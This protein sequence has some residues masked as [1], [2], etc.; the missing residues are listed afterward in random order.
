MITVVTLYSHTIVFAG[1]GSI[2]GDGYPGAGD[3]IE[4]QEL[5]AFPVPR[6]VLI[7]KLEKLVHYLPG[8]SIRLKN[9][10]NLFLDGRF[11]TY[12]I[13][14]KS[15]HPAGFE[16]SLW[17]WAAL[18][19]WEDF[20]TLPLESATL[21]PA[22]DSQVKV[23]FHELLHLVNTGTHEL[24]TQRLDTLLMAIF[25]TSPEASPEKFQA[26]L[27]QF[28]NNL[29]PTMHHAW[30]YSDFVEFA[31]LMK[32][33]APCE[34]FET[35]YLTPF[36]IPQK[37]TPTYLTQDFYNKNIFI[38]A[39]WKYCYGVKHDYPLNMT[40]H[41]NPDY[42]DGPNHNMDTILVKQAFSNPDKSKQL[43]EEILEYVTE[44][45]PMT[46]YIDVGP[47]EIEE[48]RYAT[49][50]E[51]FWGNERTIVKKYPTHQNSL[52]VKG[53]ESESFSYRDGGL[54]FWEKF[55]SNFWFNDI[56]SFKPAVSELK[57]IGI[58]F[59]A[60]VRSQEYFFKPRFIIEENLLELSE[61]IFFN[62]KK[63]HISLIPAEPY[64]QFSFRVSE[65]LKAKFQTLACEFV[66]KGEFHCEGK[67]QDGKILALPLLSRVEHNFLTRAQAYDGIM[68]HFYPSN[69]FSLGKDPADQYLENIFLKRPPLFDWLT[70]IFGTDQWVHG[71][72]YRMPF[73]VWSKEFD[74]SDKW[75]TA[76]DERDNSSTFDD[77]SVKMN[78]GIGQNHFRF[79]I[80]FFKEN[81]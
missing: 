59:S 58:H 38:K 3:R 10:L 56:A 47:F 70:S 53:I 31:K 66:R 62:Q 15:S 26:L 20:H 25:Y 77:D 17:A 45:N 54:Y 32:L 37:R 30:G 22:E 71:Y 55:K 57:D 13:P 72:S 1:G 64:K 12:S 16:A 36:Q 9:V 35:V 40:A 75:S 23:I 81:Q 69:L 48:R 43:Y 51:Q 63:A 33:N 28:Q 67:T 68:S 50:W 14:Q 79:S 11:K 5:I 76:L 6:E 7:P 78:R 74:L 19:L 52:F 8:F 41:E 65:S 39:Y 61:Y 21:N 42:Y 27:D 80:Y 73:G 60:N 34:D 29:L 18:Y 44:Q 46:L 2:A 24:S 4:K 49:P